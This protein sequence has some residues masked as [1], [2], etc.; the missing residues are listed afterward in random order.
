MRNIPDFYMEIEWKIESWLPFVSSMA[1]RDTFKIW[2]K[3]DMLRFDSTLRGMTGRE[4]Q[5]GL[6]SFLFTG[7]SIYLVDHD[8]RHWSDALAY[9][10]NPSYS[11]IRREVQ[12]MM[13]DTSRGLPQM[14]SNDVV[15]ERRRT[16]FGGLAKE[17]V[18]R[19]MCKQYELQGLA[20]SVVKPASEHVSS[21]SRRDN[22]PEFDAYFDYV[23]PTKKKK[24][25]VQKNNKSSSSDERQVKQKSQKS[26]GYAALNDDDDDAEEE[27]EDE[28][29]D[30]DD[31]Q[32]A[33][34][35]DGDAAAAKQQS[36]NKKKKNNNNN[37]DNNSSATSLTN[38]DGE[39][40]KKDDGDDDDDD[41]SNDPAFT[42]DRNVVSAS[43]WMADKFPLSCDDLMTIVEIISPASSDIAQLRDI[44]AVQLPA[45]FPI[46]L[47][48]PLL[49]MVSASVTF[50][51]FEQTDATD[52]AI[53][54][55]PTDYSG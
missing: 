22:M 10:R 14:N 29:D 12:S 25:P 43:V 52:A 42:M 30:G 13:R 9:F 44:L 2:K 54:R 45:G 49:P 41:V 21:E 23:R 19:Y 8:N 38:D 7:Q 17:K 31:G 48:I 53:F 46:K 51:K 40:K 50:S 1:P 5:R 33:D 11:R 16:F 3:Q 15:I 36:G 55:I 26:G 34:A 39:A 27:E 35:A 6:M 37:K 24:Q 18:G 28:E 4:V 47:V 32:Q 20:F